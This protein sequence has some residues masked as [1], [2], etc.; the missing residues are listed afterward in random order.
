LLFKSAEG[1]PSAVAT[2]EIS[3]RHFHAFVLSTCLA[4][5][6]GIAG[7]GI[8]RAGDNPDGER[9]GPTKSQ[10]DENRIDPSSAPDLRERGTTGTG[11]AGGGTVDPDYRAL[12]NAPKRGTDGIVRPPGASDAPQP[13]KSSMR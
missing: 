12:Q 7:A 1:R 2:K 8:A 5:V 6:V 9:P 13:P 10:T 11:N 4:S 3:M